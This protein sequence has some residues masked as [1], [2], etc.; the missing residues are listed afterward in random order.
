[1]ICDWTGT[2]SNKWSGTNNT[3]TGGRSYNN[4]YCFVI[5]LGDGKLRDII[6]YMDAEPVSSVPGE[7][8]V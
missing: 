4:A 8:A 2:G 7:R 6:G 1:M 5:D 3:T